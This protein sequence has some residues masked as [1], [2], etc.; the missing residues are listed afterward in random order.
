MYYFWYFILE[1]FFAKLISLKEWVLV[2]RDVYKKGSAVLLNTYRWSWLKI[3]CF[4]KISSDN[5]Q[6]TCRTIFIKYKF[7]TV[8]GSR[9]P[10]G[11][12]TVSADWL[13]VNSNRRAFVRVNYDDY[14][15]NALMR[16]IKQNRT[17]CFK[18]VIV[19]MKQLTFLIMRGTASREGEVKNLSVWYW[20]MLAKDKSHHMGDFKNRA[21]AIRYY[22]YTV[23]SSRPTL[24]FF[25][26]KWHT[27]SKL[28]KSVYLRIAAFSLLYY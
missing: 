19:T 18:E 27:F 5:F 13:A 24:L 9:C 17:V 20:Y 1:N 8:S 6:N 25:S 26:H 10:T 4:I 11:P 12:V 21:S 14:S 22:R 28:L 7:C 2:P 23:F 15:W 16:Q 3:A